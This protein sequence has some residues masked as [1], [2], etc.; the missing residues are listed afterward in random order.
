MMVTMLFQGERLATAVSDWLGHFFSNSGWT[1][2]L[3]QN[4]RVG[5]GAGREMPKALQR[6][7]DAI[8]ESGAHFSKRLLS[9][10]K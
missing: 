6:A 8:S 4:E 7:P 5:S 9:S 3:I 1:V 10:L 2:L